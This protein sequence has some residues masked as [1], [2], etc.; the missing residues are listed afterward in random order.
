M[1]GACDV[2]HRTFFV[3]AHPR[4]EDANRR[5]TPKQSP[6]HATSSH[7]KYEIKTNKPFH[8]PLSQTARPEHQ[9]SSRTVSDRTRCD[10]RPR[11]RSPGGRRQPRH[12]RETV[13]LLNVQNGPAPNT[14]SERSQRPPF[15]V[16]GRLDPKACDAVTGLSKSASFYFG[17]ASRSKTT[18]PTIYGVLRSVARTKLRDLCKNSRRRVKTRGQQDASLSRRRVVCWSLV[19][20]VSHEQQ[21][22]CLLTVSVV[23]LVIIRARARAASAD[24][25]PCVIRGYHQSICV[26]VVRPPK[27]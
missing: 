9:S 22:L 7:V 4:L 14:F 13:L 26:C 2:R 11:R 3:V 1:E 5:K 6:S 19:S 15:S 27:M 18:L 23:Q 20:V 10:G 24:G 25:Q 8:R 16:S 21:K 12:A 17:E